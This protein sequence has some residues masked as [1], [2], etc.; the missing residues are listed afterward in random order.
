MSHY[1]NVGGTWKEAANVAVNVGGVWKQV[2]N[3]S[4]KV[5]GTWKVVWENLGSTMPNIS[6]YDF[7]IQ[8]LNASVGFDL[9]ANGTFDEIQNGAV[10]N[11]GTWKKGG[12]ASQYDVQFLKTAGDN[13]TSGDTINT[14]HNIT[15]TRNWGL[16]EST[17]GFASK[18]CSGYLLIRQNASPQ[19]IFSN[20]TVSMTCEVEV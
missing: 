12:V 19:T 18:S 10:S 2:A 17:N 5:G 1:V 3:V 20:T 14:W 11:S 8:P 4:V 16:V 13:P 9:Y 6:M 7:A 15:T